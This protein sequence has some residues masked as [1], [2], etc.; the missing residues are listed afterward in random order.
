MF[1]RTILAAF[2]STFI[3][4]YAAVTHAT[5]QA[6]PRPPNVLL[7][8]MD[9]QGYQ[10][11]GCF[12]SPT[13]KTPHIDSIASDGMRFTS[14]Y[15][16]SSVCSPSRAA[17]LTGRYPLRAE[18][19][20]VLFPWFDW[21]LKKEQLTIAEVLKNKGYATAC[22]GKWHLGSKPEFLPT[23]H[24]FDYYYG[25]PYSNDMAFWDSVPLATNVLFTQEVDL[26]EYRTLKYNARN[27]LFGLYGF[28]PLVKN[29]KVVELPADQATLT[30]RY[31]DEAI[32]FMKDHADEPFFV[33]LPH[34]MPHIP[35]YTEKAFEGR[36]PAGPYAD[37]IE[38]VDHHVGRLLATLDEL[39]L[40]DNTLVIFTSDNGP[41]KLDNKGRKW[42]GS[43]APLRGHKFSSYEGGFREPCVMRFP[44]TIPPGSTCNEVAGTIDLL[45]TIALLTGSTLPA[46]HIIDGKDI[47]ALMKASP[48]ATS[49]HDAYYFY[50]ANSTRLDGVRIGKWKLL[51]LKK[52]ALYDL[53]NDIGET[54]NVAD[55]YPEIVA[56]LTAQMA[57]FDASLKTNIQL[58]EAYLKKHRKK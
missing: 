18:V 22:I 56:K 28:P 54:T 17:L 55:Q 51:K 4:F 12:G 35:L 1:N 46:E 34:S 25:I 38:E 48:K 11:L 39:K 40:A 58:P 52:Q 23:E 57:D 47:S 42:G 7:I 13:I 50:H 15:S 19:P 2:L 24:G 27:R 49:P 9:D 10:D 6:T 41:W 14:F 21:G 45:P 36:N 30:R 31:T 16:A 53:E 29:K 44:G 20:E 33:Y 3:C 5:E 43:A 37:C 26:E 32:R 8:F